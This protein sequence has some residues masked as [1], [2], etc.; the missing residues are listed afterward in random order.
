MKDFRIKELR[1]KEVCVI[2][3]LTVYPPSFQT[4][5]GKDLS[6]G[7]SPSWVSH[8]TSN[9]GS[10]KFLQQH[11]SA[12]AVALALDLTSWWTMSL[13]ISSTL[14]QACIGSRRSVSCASTARRKTKAHGQCQRFW[15]GSQVV[16]VVWF[17]HKLEWKKSRT[18]G[19]HRYGLPAL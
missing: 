9:T 16:V 11:A 8:N 2:G 7:S 13:M 6:N 5:A 15:G 4:S 14:R 19:D 12:T 1:E 18:L 17:V 10:S 3:A